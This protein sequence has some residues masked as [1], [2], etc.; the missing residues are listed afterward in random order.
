EVATPRERALTRVEIE[1]DNPVSP[2]DFEAVEGVTDVV[3]SE[4]RLTCSVTGSVDSL[5]KA[6]ARHTVNKIESARP[7][8]EEVFLAY[9]SE[10]ARKEGPGAA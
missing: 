10:G 7:G 4:H 1:F 3:V 5:I 8:L 9:Y 6:A 2:A